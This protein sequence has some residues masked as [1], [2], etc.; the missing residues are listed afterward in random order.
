M[1]HPWLY[2]HFLLIY[3]PWWAAMLIAHKGSSLSPP[4]SHFLSPPSLLPPSFLFSLLPLISDSL[5]GGHN[6][7]FTAGPARARWQPGE[8]ME[9]PSHP[10]VCHWGHT[11]RTTRK[12]GYMMCVCLPICLCVCVCVCVCM[13]ER[14]RETEGESVIKLYGYGVYLCDCSYCA[15]KC[16]SE[17]PKYSFRWSVNKFCNILEIRCVQT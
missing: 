7:V 17:R 12:T 1:Y 8:S 14:E 13:C 3:S 2:F 5:G 15:T 16:S 6:P 9:K 10:A 11:A 4:A